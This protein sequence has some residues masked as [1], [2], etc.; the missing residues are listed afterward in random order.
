MPKRFRDWKIQTKMT[1]LAVILVLLPILAISIIA[2]ARFTSSLRKAAEA[3]LEHILRNVV[4]ICRIQQGL[5]QQKV[6][7]DLVV[8]QTLLKTYGTHIVEDPTTVVPIMAVNQ[9]TQEARHIQVPLWRIDNKPITQTSWFV[10]EVQRLVGGTCTV[11]QRIDSV[12]FLRISTNVLQKDARRAVGT[13]IPKTSLVVQSILK[14]ETFIGRAFV[15]NSWHTA[16]YAPLR[17]E[18]ERIIGAIYVGTREQS[19]D[20]LEKAI[21]RIKVGE[22]GYAFVVDAKGNIITHPTKA[23]RNVVSLD[24]PAESEVIAQIIKL[25]TKLNDNEVGTIRYPWVN[26]ELGEKTPRMKIAKYMSFPDW[27]WI[28]TAGSYEEEIYAAVGKTRLFIYPVAAAI[29]AVAVVVAVFLSR[30]LTQPILNLTEIT[31]RMARGDFS[32]HADTSSQDEVGFLARSFNEMARQVRDNTENLE[33]IVTERTTKLVESE[34]RYRRLFEGSKDGIYISTVEGRF[35]DVNRSAVELFGYDS[36]EELLSIDIPHDLYVKPEDRQRMKDEILKKGFV[37]DFEQQLKKKDGTEVFVLITSNLIRDTQGK[38]FGYEGIMRDITER[39]RLDAELKKTQAY[40][41]Q[42]A[43][44]RALGDLVAGVAHEL[45]NPLMASETI[46]HVV[47]ENLHEDCPNRTRVELTQECNRRMAKIINH[48]REFSRQAKAVFEPLD[49]HV[50]IENALMIMQQQL[51]SRNITTIKDLAPGLPRI[52]ADSNQLEQVFL[53]LISNARDS[54]EGGGDQRTELTIQTALVKTNEQQ[55]LEV[56]I[57][58]TGSGIPKEIMDK[59]F[60][61]FF[62]TKQVKEGMGLGLAICYG[63]VESHGGRIV[64]DSQED[65]GTTFKVFLPVPRGGENVKA[66]SSGG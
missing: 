57:R 49:I 15:V 48:L 31:T 61:P 50:P 62:T 64:V 36:K 25:G 46:L 22:T 10:D 33:Q 39:K 53:N 54:M 11:F 59:I 14:N 13:Y 45:N 17:D 5:L 32:R 42:A 65:R 52:L 20:A 47:H 34:A 55:D 35:L 28:I 18:Q 1:T 9:E 24:D 6:T 66:N 19:T 60:E 37:K 27:D 30:I 16:A 40:L 38:P 3:D 26:V 29:M 44:M 21:A 12:G 41:I 56:T 51:L 58:D 23:G 63:I 7:S 43:K 2:I 4:S 8:A